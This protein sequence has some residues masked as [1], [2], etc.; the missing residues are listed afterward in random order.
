MSYVKSLSRKFFFI[1]FCM[2]LVLATHSRSQTTTGTITGTVVDPNGGV[3]PSA[4]VTLTSAQ[5]GATRNLV[6]NEEGRFTFVAIQPG[7]YAVVVERSGFQKLLREKVVLSANENLA[8]GELPLA[9]GNPNE[10]VTITGT[11]ATV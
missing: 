6:T 5:T 9:I 7:V 2:M 8:L 10:T 1:G 4:N 11:G 3:V